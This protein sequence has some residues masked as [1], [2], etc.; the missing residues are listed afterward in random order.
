[1]QLS[2]QC[3]DDW[4]RT[5]DTRIF[6]TRLMPPG[7]SKQYILIQNGTNG[8]KT[9]HKYRTLVPAFFLIS[10]LNC[11]SAMSIMVSNAAIFSFSA[12]GSF[13]SSGSSPFIISWMLGCVSCVFALQEYC[14]SHHCKQGIIIKYMPWYS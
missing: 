4:N 13:L 5:S 3:G 14:F 1:M 10:I 2:F 8:C 6:S 7:S 9:A 11:F 12:L